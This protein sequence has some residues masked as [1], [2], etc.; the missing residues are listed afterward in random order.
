MLGKIEQDHVRPILYAFQHNVAAVG[1]DVKVANVE[2]RQEVRQLAFAAGIEIDELEILVLNFSPKY[3]EFV[4]SGE[5]GN[6]AAA[7][8]QSRKRVGRGLG[9]DDLNRKCCTDVW[10]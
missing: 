3:D 8:S 2:L 10:T 5:K 7:A 9:R 1:S 4:T 6:V